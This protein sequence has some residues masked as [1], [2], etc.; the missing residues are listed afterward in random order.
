[1]AAICDVC[2]FFSL[3][4]DDGCNGYLAPVRQ[5][6]VSMHDIC[7]YVRDL[8]HK[9]HVRKPPL[10]DLKLHNRNHTLQSLAFLF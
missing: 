6:Y 10:L 4:N 1:M 3:T 8:V 9:F 7:L 5:I 2:T